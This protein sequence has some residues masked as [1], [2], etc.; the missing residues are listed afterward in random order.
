MG[1]TTDDSVRTEE[2]SEQAS[3]QFNLILQESIGK[4]GY[5]Q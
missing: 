1:R 3:L 4:Q 5:Y 2:S